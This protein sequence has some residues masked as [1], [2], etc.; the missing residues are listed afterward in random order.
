MSLR[1]AVPATPIRPVPSRPNVVGSGIRESW[2]IKLTPALPR[3]STP[4][5]IPKLNAVLP[6]VSIVVGCRN[7]PI[8][9]LSVPETNKFP[10]VRLSLNMPWAF[11]TVKVPPVN[12]NNPGTGSDKVPVLI[13]KVA[14]LPVIEIV[15][16]LLFAMAPLIVPLIKSPLAMVVG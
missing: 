2:P 14:K 9:K 11:L 13:V 4:F 8:V 12:T 3:D 7:P 16:M 6:D 1:L 5:S 10:L 15:I